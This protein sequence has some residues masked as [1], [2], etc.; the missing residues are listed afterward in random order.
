MRVSI[1]NHLVTDGVLQ[2]I[3]VEVAALLNSRPFDA[4]Q[5]GPGRFWPINSKSFSAWWSPFPNCAES[6]TPLKMWRTWTLRQNSYCKVN[7]LFNISGIDERE[8]VLHLTKRRKSTENQP[9]ITLGDL[10]LVTLPNTLRGL[11]PLRKVIEIMPSSSDNVVQMEKVKIRNQKYPWII[12]ATMF[13]LRP[14]SRDFRSKVNHNCLQW[15]TITL[16]KDVNVCKIGMYV[17]HYL[18]MKKLTV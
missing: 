9:N 2:T 17:Q 10:V 11:W 12:P 4:S 18:N 7:P 1:G 5:H 8:Y 14:K 15:S 13:W 3:V 6:F 16:V